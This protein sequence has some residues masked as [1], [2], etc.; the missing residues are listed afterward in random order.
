MKIVSRRNLA[1]LLLLPALMWGRPA[2]ANDDA[3]Q[4]KPEHVGL[5]SE[6]LERIDKLMQ[7]YVDEERISGA[8]GLIA[9][10]V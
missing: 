2:A 8:L 7:R 3:P 5:S 1:L 9:R 6:R 10:H 4:V